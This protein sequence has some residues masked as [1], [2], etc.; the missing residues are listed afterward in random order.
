MLNVSDRS[1]SG[2]L[3]ASHP[4]VAS[5]VATL[6]ASLATSSAA[7]GATNACATFEGSPNPEGN[8]PQNPPPRGEVHSRHG[9]S[10]IS[11]HKG[12]LR[13]LS[14]ACTAG[15]WKDPCSER[16]GQAYWNGELL[17]VG[18]FRNWLG[19][20]VTL[21]S[22]STSESWDSSFPWE[23]LPSVRACRR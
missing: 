6:H 15:S 23:H 12:T 19:K 17:S 4:W 2:S 8:A 18:A 20:L 16:V 14:S 1:D 7:S 13:Q 5:L 3:V 9:R 21:C 22:E 11:I 10:S